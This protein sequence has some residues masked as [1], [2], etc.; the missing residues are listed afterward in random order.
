M[1]YDKIPY[2]RWALFREAIDILRDEY[3]W[4]QI[5]ELFGYSS[6]GWAS[7]AYQHRSIVDERDVQRALELA[8]QHKMETTK[9]KENGARSDMP[10]E[11]QRRTAAAALVREARE[12]HDLTWQELYN[13]I[14]QHYSS[15]GSFSSVARQWTTGEST[16]PP[17]VLRDLKSAVF[18]L[19]QGYE[20]GGEQT[21]ENTGARSWDWM[22]DVR[23]QLGQIADEL[24]SCAQ[25]REPE[26]MELAYRIEAEAEKVPPA[27]RGPYE[28]LA[29]RLLEAAGKIP[30]RI[31]EPLDEITDDL[32][33]PD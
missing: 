6:Q 19:R 25:Q 10:D 13:L 32:E 26:L 24:E 28:Q 31:R 22:D 7:Q 29:D 12:E 11:K 14:P 8:R 5:P 2:E 18:S 17:D 3:S 20:P 23:D 30:Q 9:E 4:G 33:R 15:S 1:S 27:F 16:P 21:A